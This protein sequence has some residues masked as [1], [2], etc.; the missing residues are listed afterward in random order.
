MYVHS[1]VREIKSEYAQRHQ[2]AAIGAEICIG[3]FRLSLEQ[4]FERLDDVRVA[5]DDLLEPSGFTGDRP[6]G[7][8]KDVGLDETYYRPWNRQ[9]LKNPR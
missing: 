1:I 9:L 8:R 3:V 2:R 4:F 7:R 5:H 6:E